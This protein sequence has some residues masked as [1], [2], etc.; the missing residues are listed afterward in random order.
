MSGIA[1]VRKPG[2][3]ISEG[4]VTHIEREPVDHER[5]AAQHDA[6][7]AALARHGWRPVYVAAADELPDAPF[8]EDTLVVS[9]RLA[10]LTRPGAPERRPEVAAV[11]QAVREAGLTTVRIAR[12]GTLDGGDVLQANATVYVGRS[13][14]SNREGIMQLAALL[15]ERRVVPVDMSGV[16]HLKSAVT[17]LPD[18]TLIGDPGRVDLPDLLVPPE[19][20][21]A[22][23]V[24]LG[25][26]SVLMAASAPE[27]AALLGKRGFIVTSVDISE[28]EKLEGCVTCLSVLV[29]D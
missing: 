28:F 25:G 1:L 22:H 20:A 8:V 23:V 19:E 24:P 17:A 9:G 27:T 2:P 12:P 18:G 21:G 14:R 6:Y 29:P 11:E 26:D 7:V 15:P 4:I 10:V 3:R 16:L 5:A 13:A